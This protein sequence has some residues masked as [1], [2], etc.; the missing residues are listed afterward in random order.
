MLVL[1]LFLAGMSY[2]FILL[3]SDVYVY[4]SAVAENTVLA[5][6]EPLVALYDFNR[7]RVCRTELHRFVVRTND[8]AV[9]HREITA[10][11]ALPPG[12]TKVKNVI[13]LP[14]LLPGDY[15]FH[16][17]TFGEC[18]EGSHADY[19]IPVKFTVTFKPSSQ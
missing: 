18:S 15:S 5:P 2:N 1:G 13:A 7:K 11:G 14:V 9:V 12:R 10:G 4:Y 3:H 19:G 17:F 6:G 8:N 16:T